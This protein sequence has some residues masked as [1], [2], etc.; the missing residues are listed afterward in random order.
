MILCAFSYIL[1]KKINIALITQIQN[2]LLFSY[3][4]KQSFG[5]F[6]LQDLRNLH[7][8]AGIIATANCENSPSIVAVPWQ[9]SPSFLL[10]VV[11]QWSPL[12]ILLAAFPPRLRFR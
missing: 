8:A 5:G 11:P 4:F 7:E 10:L 2:L 12:I 3:L 1:D 9:P 6:R